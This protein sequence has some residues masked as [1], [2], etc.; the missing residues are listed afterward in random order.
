MVGLPKF[1]YAYIIDRQKHL[2]VKVFVMR[3]E[4]GLQNLDQSIPESRM[5]TVPRRP[6]TAG[7]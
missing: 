7:E 6:G 1:Y 3:Q 5:Q 2:I 4:G